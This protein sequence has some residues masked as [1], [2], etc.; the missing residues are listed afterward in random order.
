M[1]DFRQTLFKYRSYTPI[2][3]LLAL[4]FMAQPTPVSFAAGLCLVSVG[5]F[6]RLWGVSYAGSETR[7]TGPVGA[8]SLITGGPFSHVRNPLY[9]GN[10]LLYTGFGIMANL[11]AL[12]LAGFIYFF[13]QY[14]L[15]VSL[16]EEQL[17]K[18]FLDE[19]AKYFEAVPRFVPALK[20]Y[21][22]ARPGVKADW[23]KGLRSEQRTLQAILIVIL[24]ITAIWIFRS[25]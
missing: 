16:E 15:I 2:P 23:K 19:Y 4:I 25:Q 17:T 24:V 6:F 9:L 3:F 13:L 18:K 1:M 7:T 8:T 10:L 14:T 5:E 20:K 11:P 12:A 22:V 21:E